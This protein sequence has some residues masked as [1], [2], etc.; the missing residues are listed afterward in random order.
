MARLLALTLHNIRNI[1]NGEITFETLPSAGSVT[2]IYGANGSGKTSML[3][4]IRLLRPTISGEPLPEDATELVSIG[5]SEAELSALFRVRVND[6]ERYL[7]YTV[8]YR[9]IDSVLRIAQESVC[10]G[11]SERRLGRPFVRYTVTVDDRNRLD[12]S[13]V[14]RW[15]S[16]VAAV[17]DKVAVALWGAAC[18]A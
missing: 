1:G 8:V 17:D 5:E 2:G 9:R 15:Q 11:D 7:K 12:L 3:D 14:I 13:P 6:G 16:I 4:A 10:V 18:V